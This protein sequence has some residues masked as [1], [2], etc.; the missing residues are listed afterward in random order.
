MVFDAMIL[1]PELTCSQG[2]YLSSTSGQINTSAASKSGVDAGDFTKLDSPLMMELMAKRPKL[3]VGI[4]HV[5]CGSW[6]KNAR[7][8]PG[9]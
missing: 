8:R 3:I 1:P 5:F 6:R 2:G 9:G 4:V 7:T